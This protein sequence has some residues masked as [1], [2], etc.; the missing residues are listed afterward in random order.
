MVKHLVAVVF[1]FQGPIILSGQGFSLYND[2]HIASELL[3]ERDTTS[4]FYREIEQDD[5]RN[6]LGAGLADPL[7]Y[8][9]LRFIYERRFGPGSFSV[10]FP[11]TIGLNGNA[12][13]IEVFRERNLNLRTGAG[14]NFYVPR[15]RGP[16]VLILGTG[17]FGGRYKSFDYDRW[18]N[19][20]KTFLALNTT[21]SIHLHLCKSFILATGLDISLLGYNYLGYTYASRISMLNAAAIRIDLLFNF[22]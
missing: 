1:L 7:L 15:L 14:F 9:N 10:C 5:R 16:S 3:A 21:C 22:K 20:S 11:L 12:D 13:Q 2:H 6:Y 4:G 8:R 18:R 19:E 17:I